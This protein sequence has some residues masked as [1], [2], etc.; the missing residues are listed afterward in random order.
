MAIDYGDSRVGVAVS[1]A[2]GITA[3]GVETIKNTGRR[4]LFSRL[5]ELIDEYK[6]SVI[7][8]GLPKNMNGTLGERAEKSIEFEKQL[9]EIYDGKTELFDERLTTVSAIR[10]LNETN[11]RGQ[12]RK[13]VVD[14]VAAV[15]ILQAYMERMK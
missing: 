3:Q 4:A 2:L 8:I 5:G 6:P 14:T 13:N 10:T 7:V 1:D 15:L 9:K 12:K 11:T